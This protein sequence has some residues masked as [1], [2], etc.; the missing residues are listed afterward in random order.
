MLHLA[1]PGGVGTQVGKITVI[2]S[3]TGPD[4]LPAPR[5]HFGCSSARAKLATGV[6]VAKMQQ[7]GFVLHGRGKRSWAGDLRAAPLTPLPGYNEGPCC[8]LQINWVSYHFLIKNTLVYNVLGHLRNSI[9]NKCKQQQ[10]IGTAGFSW[11][12]IDSSL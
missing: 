7:F 9:N 5:A 8:R 1:S 12:G 6:G 2:G 4:V 10:F 3:T 11:I